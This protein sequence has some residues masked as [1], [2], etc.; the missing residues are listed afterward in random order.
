MRFTRWESFWIVNL[1]KT[2]E[3]ECTWSRRKDT[4]WHLPGTKKTHRHTHPKS[5]MRRLGC[6]VQKRVSQGKDLAARMWL[7]PTNLG[8]F[9]SF[10]WWAH[11]SLYK[12]LLT[13]STFYCYWKGERGKVSSKQRERKRRFYFEVF[14]SH[15]SHSFSFS[16]TNKSVGTLKCW[17]FFFGL[18]LF[19]L[20]CFF[21]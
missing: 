2:V 14:K 8:G 6:S 16:S 18:V 1:G 19:F 21:W 9:S 15:E 4:N 5:K 20:G 11:P 7:S 10:R 13:L 3:K 17:R 12:P